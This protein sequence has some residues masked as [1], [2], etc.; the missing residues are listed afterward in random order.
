MK[1][2]IEGIYYKVL[3]FVIAIAFVGIA[4]NPWLKP[5]SANAAGKCI[6][7]PGVVRIDN[8]YFLDTCDLRTYRNNLRNGVLTQDITLKLENK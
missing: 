4:I 8:D 6:L 5:E 1:I 7:S 3:F 2:G